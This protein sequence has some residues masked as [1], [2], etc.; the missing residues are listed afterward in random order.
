MKEGRMRGRGERKKAGW[1]EV[2]QEEM[3]AER[4]N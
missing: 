3:E 4:K 1:K 2:R